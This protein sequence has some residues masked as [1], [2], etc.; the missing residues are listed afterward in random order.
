M[1][2]VLAFDFGASNGRALLG[3]ITDGRIVYTEVHRFPNDPVSV[4]GQL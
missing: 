3:E 4:N 2:R 1:K